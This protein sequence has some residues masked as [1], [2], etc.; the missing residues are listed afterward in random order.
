LSSTFAEE[1]RLLLTGHAESAQ[2]WDTNTGRP[3]HPPIHPAGGVWPA[4]SPLGRRLAVVETRIDKEGRRLENWLRIWD[5]TTGKAM[6][7]P[8]AKKSPKD[9]AYSE[10]LFSPNGKRLLAFSGLREQ[11]RLQVWD[12]EK[13]RPLTPLIPCSMHAFSADG[14]RLLT[15]TDWKSGKSWDAETGAFL[16]EVAPARFLATV[17]DGQIYLNP[18]VSEVPPAGFP[19]APIKGRILRMREG[20][21]AQVFDLATNQPLSPPFKPPHGVR[22][23][24]L[25]ANGRFA[26]TLSYPTWG[27]KYVFQTNSRG[28]HAVENLIRSELRVWDARTGELVLPALPIVSAYSVEPL[29]PA[30]DVQVTRDGRKLVFCSDPITCDVWELPQD[31]RPVEELVALAQ[32]LSGRRV[33][34]S[35]GTPP[36]GPEEW[37]ALRA[38]YPE[39]CA[40]P[41]DAVRWCDHQAELAEHAG[42]WQTVREY[43]DHVIAAEPDVWMHY[44]RRGR[45][46]NNLDD[47]GAGLRDDTRAIELGANIWHVW[48]NRGLA[49]LALG[50]FKEASDDLEK[51]IGMEGV[52]PQTRF[53][54][55]T[56]RA[57]QG[58][59]A[60]YR[61][62][63]AGLLS[64]VGPYGRRTLVWLCSLAPGGVADGNVLIRLAEQDRSEAKNPQALA[65][66]RTALGAAL[67]RADK[68]QEAITVLTENKGLHGAYDGLFLAMA[69]H[70]LGQKRRAEKYLHESL[71]WVALYEADS[72]TGPRFTRVTA[73]ERRQQLRQ[74]SAEAAGLIGGPALSASLALRLAEKAHAGKPEDANTCNDLAWQLVAGPEALRDP[75]R[76]LPLAEKAVKL[77]PGEWM[78]HNTL[79]V[80]LYRLGRYK[81]AVAPL[82]TSLQRQ[83]KHLAAFDL[84]FLALCHHRLGV[85]GKAKEEYERAVQAQEQ[86]TQALSS[87]NRAELQTFR[88]EAEALLKKPCPDLSAGQ[89]AGQQKDKK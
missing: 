9:A 72:Q 81:D 46:D 7:G 67:Y 8:F 15:T 31:K 25:V 35:G 21:E 62:A 23:A 79:G 16:T 43:L 45:A 69:H 19:A 18:Y 27:M 42:D 20:L 88:R 61:R 17:G 33:D 29:Y 49:H 3:L 40:V 78:Y 70:R 30:N 1:G 57:L 53:V 58:D 82:E 2:L 34:E 36:L 85:Q 65:D 12:P 11:R 51:A 44:R 47:W 26:A 28:G 4:V 41:F 73:W 66:A 48:H 13:L 89:A 63:C 84:Y 86:N 50:H 83:Q 38:R 39:A 22:Y 5:G 68:Y 80:T 10:L 77:R 55:V 14:R 60:A 87:D 6:T 75:A 56:A 24:A 59:A 52:W 54:L 37:L 76:A 71:D 74:L 32:A 64:N